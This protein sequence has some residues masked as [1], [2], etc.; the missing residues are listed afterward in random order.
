MLKRKG[1]YF[2]LA[3][4]LVSGISIYVNKLAVNVIQEP[5]IFTTVKNCG[6][7]LLVLFYILTSG[8]VKEIKKLNRRDMG[9]LTLVGII[10][11]SIPFYLFFTGLS[12]IPAVNGA[13]IQK[14]LVLWVAILAV[15]FLHEKLSK[16]L[17]LTIL[18]LFAANVLVG[19]FKGFT[20]STGELY[21]L[22]A[23][24]FWAVET[25]LAKKILPKVD[26]SILVEAR[27][28]IGAIILL[29]LSVIFKPQAL[30]SIAILSFDKWAWIIL[31]VGLLVSY[32]SLWYRG[33]KYAPATLVTA[34]LVGSTLVT[35]ILS[36]LFVTHNLN[37]L[38]LIQSLLI[39]AGIY[40]L[41][42][43]EVTSRLGTNDINLG[44]L[45]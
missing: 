9:I 21:V 2:A 3:A 13:I 32:V 34:V 25:V 22:A 33:L 4:A 18:A 31:T 16:K 37:S 14:S 7:A 41:Y 42:K 10:G 8:K 40:V 45:K 44:Q 27:M 29:A 43:I 38:I 11:G 39:A 5:L 23:T 30:T 12:M 1:L 19:G 28:G 24:F 15:P 35:N 20:F 26:P 36:A 17:L 6:V